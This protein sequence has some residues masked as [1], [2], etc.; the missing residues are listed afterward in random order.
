LV[1]AK[2][3]A[4]PIPGFMDTKPMFGMTGTR[5]LVDCP[6]GPLA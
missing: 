6:V 5:G 3:T 4:K 1:A 2:A